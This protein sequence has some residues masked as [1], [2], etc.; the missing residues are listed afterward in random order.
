MAEKIVI[1]YAHVI[2]IFLYLVFSLVSLNAFA[3]DNCFKIVFHA[4]V[5]YDKIKLN[6]LF[7]KCWRLHS[8]GLTYYMKTS[9]STADYEKYLRCHSSRCKRPSSYWRYCSMMCVSITEMWSP[10]PVTLQTA[11]I[12]RVLS[13]VYIRRS[14]QFTASVQWRFIMWK[15]YRS[16]TLYHSNVV[17]KIPAAVAN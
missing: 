3:I 14:S 10:L 7:V 1:R 5:V 2:F 6:K 8:V 17:H 11:F 4:T 16:C 12:H 15:D 13:D 9:N